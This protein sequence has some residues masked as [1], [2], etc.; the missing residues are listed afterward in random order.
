MLNS[1]PLLI[2]AMSKQETYQHVCHLLRMR[3][4]W[5]QEGDTHAADVMT[6]LITKWYKNEP[7]V[8]EDA[9]KTMQMAGGY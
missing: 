2:N 7:S 8:T 3:K 4:R 9:F 5:L 6:R 1:S